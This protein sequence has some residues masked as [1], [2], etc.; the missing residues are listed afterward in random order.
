MTPNYFSRKITLLIALVL[1]LL[2]AIAMV[3][4]EGLRSEEHIPAGDSTWRLTLS[5]SVDALKRGATVKLSP[6]WNTKHIRVYAQNV[7]HPGAIMRRQ[8]GNARNREIN[9]V[10]ARTGQIQLSAM[11]DLHMSPNSRKIS[12]P[13]PLSAVEREA[14]IEAQPLIQVD[15][16]QLRSISELL[17][18]DE[19][20]TIEQQI[21]DYVKHEIIVDENGANDAAATVQEGVGSSLGRVRAAVALY[22]AAKIPARVVTGFALKKAAVARPR[23]WLEIYVDDLWRP[24]DLDYG[25]GYGDELPPSYVPVKRGGDSGF[26]V[27]DAVVKEAKYSITRMDAP[28]GL[29]G[30]ESRRLIHVLDLERLP[31]AIRQTLAILLLLP[32][33]VLVTTFVR[34]ILGVHTYGTFTPTLLALAITAV[35]WLSA[36]FIIVLVST[37]SIGGRSLLPRL[38]LARTARLTIVFT[39]VAL[40]LGLGVSLMEYYDF[41]PGGLSVLLPVVVLA[42]LVDRIY[43]LADSKGVAPALVR[44][45]WTTANAS[46][47]FLILLRNDWGDWIVGHPEVHLITI[48]LAISARL[49]EGPKL[50][51]QPWMRWLVEPDPAKAEAEVDGR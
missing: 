15:D 29:Y 30:E 48:A 14:L 31:I 1:A 5:I 24:L 37:I 32:I 40:S 9:A 50:A 33:G 35:D 21:L 10:S 7:S 39:L 17:A 51:N 43:T 27:T 12:A 16:S 36:L 19:G 11:F 44:L 6:P 3:A 22:R 13:T 26:S 28:P 38:K 4:R 8:T 18:V 42:T 46:I 47:C 25:Y 2:G 45:A 20:R 23:H 41:S 34:T 49:Y